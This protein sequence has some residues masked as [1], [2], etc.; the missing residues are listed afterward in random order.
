MISQESN[1]Q[2][3]RS[4]C[5]IE[6]PSGSPP[7]HALCRAPRGRPAGGMPATR[8]WPP[9]PFARVPC[10]GCFFTGGTQ[11][12][13]LA[14]HGDEDEK[15]K[16]KMDIAMSSKICWWNCKIGRVTFDM[17]EIS[18]GT[19]EDSKGC[20]EFPTNSEIQFSIHGGRRR[21]ELC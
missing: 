12:E 10:D 13:N 11:E 14:Q 9:R 18:C 1:G 8:L 17:K 19:F 16:L 2:R 4:R 5:E 6:R 20:E 15:R 3:P 21:E 7:V